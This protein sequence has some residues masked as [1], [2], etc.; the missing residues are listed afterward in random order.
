MSKKMSRREMLRALG[1][2]GAGGLLAACQPKTVIVKE[3]V[4]VE[5]VVTEVVKET[6]KETV[7]VEGTPK[8]VE[9]EVTRVVE[10]VVTAAPQPLPPL[11]GTI[12]IAT[13]GDAP[14][15]CEIEGEELGLS[16]CSWYY[17]VRDEWMQDHPNVKVEWTSVPGEDRNEVYRTQLI[18]GTMTDLVA[19]YPDQ[20]VFE[21]NLDL[22][23]DFAAELQESNPYGTFSTWEEEFPVG[24]WVFQRGWMPEPLRCFLGNTSTGDFGQT[25]FFYNVD[26][27]EAAGI[28]GVPETWSELMEACQKLKAAGFEPYFSSEM[29]RSWD[30]RW[31]PEMTMDPVIANILET[32]SE[33]TG[34]V[35]KGL[36]LSRAL[37]D[38]IGT[39]AVVKGLIRA[40]DPRFLETH[41]LEKE[42]SKYWIEDW[43]APEEIDYFLAGRV[44]MQQQGYWAMGTYRDSAERDFEFG[45]FY[46]PEID[47]AA[48]QYATGAP[49]RRTGTT[50]GGQVSTSYCVPNTTIENGNY[51]IVKDLVQFFTTRS[52]NDA[53]CSD[54]YPP[55][56]A[57]GQKIED[58]VSD[59]VELAQLWGMYH[60]QMSDAMQQREFGAIAAGDTEMRLFVQY[61]NDEI[62]LEELGAQLQAEWEREAEKAITD[63][64][65]WN[66]DAWPE[67]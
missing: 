41:R 65:Q 42:F 9:K 1:L 66:A 32:W 49:R 47:S 50:G 17:R 19:A 29:T 8:V 26:M 56:L 27:F 38:E 37:N 58:V 43:K 64:P 63:N 24:S 31:I 4:E 53:W 14:Q 59:P 45:T 18:A 25:L 13:W 15:R 6:V 48:S 28:E 61:L 40:D 7:V 30:L 34:A 39:W 33:K 22:L 2:A 21:N 62:T 5:K 55:C 35:E 23:H 67:P 12:T 60:P 3:T 10:K 52:F 54:Q 46:L 36:P 44:A 11:E 20:V 16:P 51:P 57:P